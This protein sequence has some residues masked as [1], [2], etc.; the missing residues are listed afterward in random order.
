MF[1]LTALTLI[2]AALT[3]AVSDP[4]AAP[5]EGREEGE[6]FIIARLDASSPS[7]SDPDECRVKTAPASTFK[8]PHALIALQAGV[9][10]PETVFKW[11]GT[12]LPFE[13]WQ[14]DHTLDSA[15][16]WSVLP[17]FQHTARLIGEERMRAGLSRLVYAADTFDREVS[18]F[19]LDGDLVVSPFE[20]FVFLQRFFAGKLPAAARHLSAVEDAIRMPPGQI[21]LAAGAYPFSLD[22]PEATIVRAKT[23]NTALNGERVS[24]LVG[25]L[26]LKDVEYVFVARIRSRKS[27]GSTAGTELA[28]RRLNASAHR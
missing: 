27:L 25:A 13:S 4:G 12:K 22:W 3:F 7:I 19:W 9:I 1:K 20:Q 23:G 24:W 15:M 6:C 5:R 28:R 26:E 10:T 16:R 8:I 17:Y 11:D 2:A 18:D 14:R 21:V